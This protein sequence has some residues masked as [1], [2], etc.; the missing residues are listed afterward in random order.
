[1]ID[2]EARTRLQIGRDH[3]NV[4]VLE[5]RIDVFTNLPLASLDRLTL[6]KR[7]DAIGGAEDAASSAA[8]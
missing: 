7:L 8:E 2:G 3:P 6:Q 5:R 4:L 1:M